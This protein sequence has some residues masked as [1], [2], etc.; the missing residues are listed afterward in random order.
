MRY[1]IVRLS[2]LAACSGLGTQR[3]QNARGRASGRL[4]RL[5]GG[6]AT[7]AQYARVRRAANRRT[8]G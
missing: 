1:T 3:Q 5:T 6:R 7:P 2:D 8:G 4:S